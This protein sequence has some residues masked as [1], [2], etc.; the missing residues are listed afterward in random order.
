[1]HSNTSF[2]GINFQPIYEYLD[3]CRQQPDCIIFSR[4]T[5]SSRQTR[6]EIWEKRVQSPFATVKQRSFTQQTKG[7]KVMLL[8]TL[9]QYLWS[10]CC[11]DDQRLTINRVFMASVHCYRMSSLV[12]LTWSYG[13]RAGN[14]YLPWQGKATNNDIIDSIFQPR[15][16]NETQRDEHLIILVLHHILTRPSLL[17]IIEKTTSDS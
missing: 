6:N 1:M 10:F 16:D 17:P 9:L 2:Q 15:A 5:C 11:W 8:L 13:G 3:Q 4:F 7:K 14:P 12:W